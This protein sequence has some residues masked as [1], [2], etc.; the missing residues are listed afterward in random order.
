MQ[1]RPRRLVG[2]ALATALLATA[3][4]SGGD[5][6]VQRPVTTVHGTL[7]T[8]TSMDRPSTALRDTEG[9]PFRLDERPADEV[10]VLFFGY[11]HCPDVCPQTMAN[12]A[13]ARARLPEDLRA[14]LQVVFVTE[15]PRRDT[16]RAL[17]RWLDGLDPDFIGL[18]GGN[19]A[20]AAMLA[21]LGSPETDVVERPE[22]PIKHPS[23]GDGH[24]HEHGEYGVEHTG[25][26]YAFAPEGRSVVYTGGTSQAEYAEDFA[27]LLDPDADIR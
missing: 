16:P 20:T 19:R 25:I 26:V 9:K 6:A 17:R 5:V 23:S 27:A 15:D 22:E 3:C 4:S 12:L 24:H 21:A 11:T 1:L 8:G 7:V 2:L 10:T 14:R 18:R 13:G